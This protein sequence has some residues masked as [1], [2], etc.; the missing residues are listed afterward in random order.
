MSLE[1]GLGL[2]TS[3]TGNIENQGNE[4]PEMTSEGLIF[5]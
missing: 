2:N 4:G 5:S 1:T 3:W